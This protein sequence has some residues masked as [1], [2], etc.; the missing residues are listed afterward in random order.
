MWHATPP[1]KKESQFPHYLTV[2]WLCDFL[3]LIEYSEVIA[4]TSKAEPE[5]AF[6]FL[7]WPSW[8]ILTIIMTYALEDEGPMEQKA[9]PRDKTNHWTWEWDYL[10]LD[11]PE[12]ISQLSE[13]KNWLSQH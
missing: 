6:Q 3:G 10:G 5:D 12:L 11:S 2:G 7:L 9:Q 1:I 13:N 8:R 4:W